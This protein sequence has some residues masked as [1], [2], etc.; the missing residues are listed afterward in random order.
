[1]PRQILTTLVTALF[2][3]FAG[4]WVTLVGF[5]FFGKPAG[6]E[7]NPRYRQRQRIY[8]FGGP[9]V[10]V[11]S[12]ILIGHAL[13]GYYL[14][15]HW[16]T[17]APEDAHFS[18]ELPNAPD[19]IVKEERGEFGPVSNHVVRAVV[20][21]RGISTLVRFTPLPDDF[22]DLAPEKLQEL[23]KDM[24]AAT[25]KAAK[26]MVKDEAELK[27]AAGVGRRFRIQLQEGYVLR[28]ELYFLDRTQFQLQVVAPNDQADSEIPER[29][30]HSFTYA[31]KSPAE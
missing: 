26:G 18:I 22:P 31:G 24:V 9:A 6:A 29:F 25:A 7:L 13:A 19:V 10:I 2:P 8:R 5:G 27:H 16:Q 11:L 12:L 20:Q 1:M 30:F 23:L 14:G 15:V 17:Y 4:L 3:L 21:G 28:G